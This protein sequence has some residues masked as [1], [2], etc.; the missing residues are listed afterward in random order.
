MLQGERLSIL[1]VIWVAFGDVPAYS[2]K[3]QFRNAV[4]PA[5]SNGGMPIEQPHELSG[6]VYDAARVETARIGFVHIFEVRGRQIHLCLPPSDTTL[7]QS[8]LRILDQCLSCALSQRICRLILAILMW[9]IDS[10]Q[11][12]LSLLTV[13][14]IAYVAQPMCCTG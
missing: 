1:I 7:F 13:F 4:P 2:N 12:S 10:V 8:S 3:D 5:E 14:L 9:R 6:F 11:F